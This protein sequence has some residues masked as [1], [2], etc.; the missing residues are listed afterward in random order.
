MHDVHAS[1]MYP[2][3]LPR[4]AETAV[5]ALVGIAHMPQGGG[6][7]RNGLIEQ[8]LKQRTEPHHPQSKALLAPRL[9][10]RL[11]EAAFC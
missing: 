4:L 1:D 6:D 3:L 2:V 8:Q 7:E 5:L 10:W 9:N 11:Q